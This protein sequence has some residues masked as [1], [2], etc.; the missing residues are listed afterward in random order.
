MQD[1]LS[2]ELAEEL[3]AVQERRGQEEEYR[4]APAPLIPPALEATLL[5][6]GFLAFL[7]AG[8]TLAHFEELWPEILRFLF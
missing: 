7:A 1:L 2:D 5:S 4:E 6:K 3:S 8:G